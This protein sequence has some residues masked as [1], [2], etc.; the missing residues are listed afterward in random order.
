MQAIQTKILPV[1]NTKP[2]R[3]KAYCARGNLTI[4]ADSE[5]LDNPDTGECYSYADER[6]H[7][8]AALLLIAK[9]HA[10]D[11]KEYGEK[12]RSWIDG[13]TLAT[14]CLPNGEYAHVFVKKERS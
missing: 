12:A 10:E 11:K 4:G 9:F 13:Y 8:N 5:R 7:H 1:T 3:I 6:K 14:G 2:T